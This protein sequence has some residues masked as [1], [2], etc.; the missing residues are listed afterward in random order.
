MNVWDLYMAYTLSGYNVNRLSLC[1]SFFVWRY[2]VLLSRKTV[3]D[4]GPA[5]DQHWVD[6]SCLLGLIFPS[7]VGTIGLLPGPI[8]NYR[9][10]LIPIFS[11]YHTLNHYLVS[12][13]M[14]MMPYALFPVSWKPSVLDSFWH[15]LLGII[16][17]R[18]LEHVDVPPGDDDIGTCW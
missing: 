6:V 13:R 10:V 5:L 4:A 7:L 2:S 1:F 17:V 12:I 18:C 9:G 14:I 8:I 16:V 11:R 3:Y 15:W